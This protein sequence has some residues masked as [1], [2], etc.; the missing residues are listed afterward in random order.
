[1][2]FLYFILIICMQFSN[3]NRNRVHVYNR[4]VC[5]RNKFRYIFL[6]KHAFE[7]LRAPDIYIIQVFIQIYIIDYANGSVL[8]IYLFLTIRSIHFPISYK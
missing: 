5:N 7:F 4:N 2:N 1:M 3:R 8:K 6:L